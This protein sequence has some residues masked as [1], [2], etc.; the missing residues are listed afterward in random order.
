MDRDCDEMAVLSASS[1]PEGVR[2]YTHNLQGAFVSDQLLDDLMTSEKIFLYVK[3][4]G[5]E[6]SLSNK[7]CLLPWLAPREA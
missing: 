7:R 1:I 2:D 3:C 5:K 4:Q 6:N